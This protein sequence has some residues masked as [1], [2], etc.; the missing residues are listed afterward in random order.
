M[1]PEKIWP[2]FLKTLLHSLKEEIE[3]IMKVKESSS[4]GVVAPLLFLGTARQRDPGLR[5]SAPITVISPDCLTP[6]HGFLLRLT[7]QTKQGQRTGCRGDV[8]PPFTPNLSSDR[9]LGHVSL[10]HTE[11]TVSLPTF[12]ERS[13]VG[14]VTVV[15]LLTCPPKKTA[16]PIRAALMVSALFIPSRKV[17]GTQHALQRD[18][19]NEETYRDRICRIKTKV[20][21]SGK[22]YFS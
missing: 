16:N 12:I 15:L 21:G 18:E 13:S 6:S 5:W 2:I 22:G 20:T 17:P 10:L 4:C 8:V 19:L 9:H 1:S 11:C 14:K 7:P 3:G